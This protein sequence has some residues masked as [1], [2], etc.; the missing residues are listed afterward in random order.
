LVGVGLNQGRGTW[1]ETGDEVEV[2][3]Q[4]GRTIELKKR[5]NS[6]VG[7]DDRGNDIELEPAD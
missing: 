2:T 5:G 1:K 4:D 6:F 3:L 7:E